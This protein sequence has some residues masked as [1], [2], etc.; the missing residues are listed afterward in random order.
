MIKYANERKKTGSMAPQQ[1]IFLHRCKY[2]KLGCA[3][4][5]CSRILGI[6]Y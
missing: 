4:I 1:E 3:R 6:K 5:I 2:K